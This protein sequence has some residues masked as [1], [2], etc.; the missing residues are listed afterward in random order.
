MSDENPP[1][2]IATVIPSKWATTPEKEYAD[3]KDS[4]SHYMTDEVMLKKI[5]FAYQYATEKHKD[6]MRKS[7]E[8]YIIHPVA[9]A[10]I[11]AKLKLDLPSILAAMLHDVVED[12]NTSLEEIEKNFGSDVAQL[13]DGLTKISKIT[14]RSNQEKL[15]ENFRKMVLAMAKDLRVIIVKLADRLHNMRTLDCLTTAKRVSIAQ[16]TMDIYAPLANRLGIYGIKSELE[17][18]CLKQLKNDVYKEISKAVSTKK[19][20]RV[21]YIE[22]IKSIVNTE[23]EKYG[24]KDVK[25]YGRSKHFYSIYKKMV[26][27][28]LA[29]EDIYD[30]FAFRIIVKSVKDCY[31][32]LGIIHAMWKP[33]P[34]RFKDYIAMPKANMYQSLHTTVI[35]PN[36]E[37]A[38]FQI[39]TEEMNN[40][41]E[42]GVA[43]HWAYKERG[44]KSETDLKKFSWLRQ[45]MQWES[46]LK[47]PVEFMESVRIDLFDDEIFVFTPRG[48]VIQ[49]PSGSTPLDFAFSVHTELGLKT[50]GS[51][52]NGRICPLRKKLNSGDIVEIQ[53]SAHQK[54]SKDWLGFVITSKARTKI[55]Q[56]LRAEQRENSKFIGKELLVAALQQLDVSWDKFLKSGK[57]ELLVKNAKEARLDDV[58]ISIGYGHLDAKE[59]VKRVFPEPDHGDKSLLLLKEGANPVPDSALT[60]SPRKPNQSGVLVGNMSNVLVNMARCCGPVPGDEIIGFITR[61]KGVTVHRSTCQS[62]LDLD[63]ARR[64]EVT[65]QKGEQ[66]TLHLVSLRIETQDRQGILADVTTAIAS[67]GANIQKANINVSK[68]LIGLL[69]FE[70]MVKGVEHLRMTINKIESLQG[71]ISVQR[72][73]ID[74]NHVQK[75]KRVRASRNDQ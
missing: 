42:F 29:F 50:V 8:P 43:A 3:L 68:D 13:V 32:A 15:A 64:I 20:E 44:E 34:G 53:T 37:P 47:D 9:V 21:N 66:S 36:G 28:K 41:C 74:R 55:R 70:L 5:D 69:D 1:T 49:L 16:E 48:D 72:A 2:P 62:S 38:E 51:K 25:V 26:E 18:L 58:L 12:T 60:Q 57:S 35:R 73:Q 4:L 6:Q 7:G 65:W 27:R 71:V 54:P 11:L 10:G 67:T 22:E 24:F 61:G 33:M 52:I 23:L 56:Y 59:L 63:P 45:I 17:D 31:E 19:S 46:E 75:T 39:R 14:F 40:I 30:M